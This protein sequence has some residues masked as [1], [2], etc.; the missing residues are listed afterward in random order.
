MRLP[1]LG[2]LKLTEAILDSPVERYKVLLEFGLDQ[3][4][5]SYPM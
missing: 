4:S 1:A 5:A 2:I 3:L